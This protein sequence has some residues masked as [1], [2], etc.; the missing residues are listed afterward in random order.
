MATNRNCGSPEH[1]I[2]RRGFLAGFAGGL[3][4]A[5][6]LSFSGLVQPA[7]AKQ[8]ASQQ[9]RVLLVWL[10]GGV[11]QLETWDPK[12]NTEYGGPFK[13]IPTSVPGMHVGELIPHT[14][15]QMHH[16]SIIRSVNTGE[17]VHYFG[18]VLMHTGRKI[19]PDVKYPQFG[20]VCAKMLTPDNS[21]LPGYLHITTAGAPRPDGPPGIEEAGFLGPKYASVMLPNGR[22]PYNFNRPD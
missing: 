10:G 18:A 2:S 14:A 20:N 3:G 12:P 9:K 11:S 13:S 22:E 19:A 1:D 15:K 17:E 4:A 21:P 6:A 5:G 16:L 7:A 8:L